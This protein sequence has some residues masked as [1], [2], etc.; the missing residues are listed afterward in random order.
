VALRTGSELKFDIWNTFQYAHYGNRYQLDEFNSV[1]TPLDKS[2]AA[3][4]GRESRSFLWR[5]RLNRRLPFAFRSIIEERSLFEPRLLSVRPRSTVYLIGYWQREEYFRDHAATIRRELTMRRKPS[6]QSI[7]IARRMRECESVFL[8][9]RRRDYDYRL[10]PDYYHAAM[11]MLSER[12]RSP[13]TF[14]FGDDLEWAR[15]ELRFP[16]EVHFVDHNGESKNYED[17]WLM[18]QC[19]HAVIA[20]SSFSWWGAWLNSEAQRV[21]VA[22]GAWGYRAAPAAGWLTVSPDRCGVPFSR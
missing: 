9:V 12:I 19:R 4:F 8:H 11:E 20:N 7:A 2:E 5:R 16:A 18:T 17:L 1:G 10:S 21:V 6:P 15:R 22:P 14:V 13:S 3:V